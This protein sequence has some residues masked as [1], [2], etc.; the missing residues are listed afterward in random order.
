MLVRHQPL[1][2]GVGR[3]GAHVRINLSPTGV[4][5]ANEVAPTAGY[6]RK[7]RRL[8]GRVPAQKVEASAINHLEQKVKGFVPLGRLHRGFVEHSDQ[9][10]EVIQVLTQRVAPSQREFFARLFTILEMAM[11]A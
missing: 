7:R 3:R 6:R 1:P 8:R 5:A 4:V 2:Y 10:V 11:N 9:C